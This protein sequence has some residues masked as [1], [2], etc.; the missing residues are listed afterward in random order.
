[1]S[2]GVPFTF[3]D[4]GPAVVEFDGTALGETFDSGI[5]FKDEQTAED[6]FELAH[7]GAPVDG[8]LT[9][10]SVSG[11]ITLTRLTLAELAILIPGATIAGDVLTVANQVGGA[12][13]DSAKEMIIKP[14]A[15]A[16]A[17]VDP[18]E[19]FTVFKTYIIEATE[20][21]FDLT[22]QRSV[23]IIVKVFP[24]DTSPNVGDFYKQGE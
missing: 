17:S 1:M 6:V 11:E 24:S 14:M 4:M 5:V 16:A 9:G 15:N 22:S 23:K 20:F 19:W 3:R 10:K 18:G 7:G 21:V 12:M 2:L 8:V 13:Y